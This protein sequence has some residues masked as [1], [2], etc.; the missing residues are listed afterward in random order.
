MRRFLLLLILLPVASIN[1]ANAQ[2]YSLNWNASFSPAW[3]AGTTS[4]TAN[5]VGS[6]GIN[7]TA[8]FVNSAS[9]TYQ[10]STP[11]VGTPGG[12]NW[13][14]P[15]PTLT[16]SMVL[17]VNWVNT[18]QTVT[19]T[20]TFSAPVANPGFYV[21]DIDKATAAT[22][23]TSDYLDHVTVTGISPLGASMN[24]SVTKFNPAATI[25]VTTGT[26][27]ANANPTGGQGGNAATN[28]ATGAAQD[29]TVLFSIAGTVSSVTIIYSNLN[30][31]G[32]VDPSGQAVNIGDISFAKTVPVSGN[33]FNDINGNTVING[34]ELGNKPVALFVNVVD[35]ATGN[36]IGTTTVNADGTYTVPNVATN[37]NVSIQLSNILGTIGSTLPANATIAG[38]SNT[39][40][41]II[42]SIGTGTTGL[43]NQNFGIERNPESAVNSQVIGVNPGG[44]VNTTILPSWFVNSNVGLNPNTQDYDGGTVNSI[45]IIS[46]PSNATSITVNGVIYLP[47]D[48]IWPVNGGSGL[49]IPAPGG[50]PSQTITV[51]PVDG[52]VG[53]VIP[54]TAIDNAGV[55]DLSPG[56]VTL[57]Y[58]SILPITLESFTAAVQ[59]NT[60]LLKWIVETE[61]NVSFYQI[62]T[63]MDGIHFTNTGNITANNNRD[64]SFLISSPAKGVNY[65]RLKTV[66]KDGFVTYS[67]IRKVIFWKNST[68]EIF[69]NPA[70]DILNI[71]FTNDLANKPAIVK[72]FSAD[73]KL[74]IQQK[75]M[76]ANAIETINVNK[77]LNGNYLLM[78]E[79]NG[80]VI[81]RQLQIIK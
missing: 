77:L 60:V 38:Y 4:H 69:P 49:T 6:S 58:I 33:V 8:T 52:I 11:A 35:V 80:K 41:L 15:T 68:L 57:Q 28:A 23:G 5:N 56:S 37:T 3:V 1:I 12:I 76:L 51:D 20:I 25:V 73:G 74:L 65:F 44:T 31:G 2:I 21:G 39:T 70:K 45:R 54:F 27:A 22:T 43:T 79:G 17:W 59:G 10:N 53:V 78:I 18:N 36:I 16:G 42:S 67:E 72:I 9:G 40:P 66:D 61:I 71:A 55:E 24:S 30:T 14:L 75:Y 64:Y 32:S 81:N 47:T 46:F 34:G 63:S 19:A 13:T 7:V 48:L 50:S 26:N 62:E 29:G